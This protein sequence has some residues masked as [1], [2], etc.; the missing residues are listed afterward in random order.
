MNQN[1]YLRRY[2]YI[3]FKYK[4][5]CDNKNKEK[6]ETMFEFLGIWA[7]ILELHR[8]TVKKHSSHRGRGRV[9]S[10]SQLKQKLLSL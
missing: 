10:V 6:R 8:C 7:F 4:P 5:D 3:L 9:N 2:Y 1:E